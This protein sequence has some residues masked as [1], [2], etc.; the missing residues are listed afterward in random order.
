MAKLD[1]KDSLWPVC[2]EKKGRKGKDS[3]E[4]M[5]REAFAL[6]YE[7]KVRTARKGR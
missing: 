4:R 2:Q 7:G 1:L 6:G 5:A 3:E